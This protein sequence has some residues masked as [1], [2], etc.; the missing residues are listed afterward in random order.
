[1]ITPPAGWTL[2]RRIDNA[3][4]PSNSLAVYRR[5]ATAGE[6]GSHTW[7]IAG[8]EFLVGGIQGFSGADT[9]N[10]LDVENGQSTPSGT[11]HSTPSVTTTVANAMLVTAHTYASSRT[12]TPGAGLT[13]GFDQPSGANS[14]TGQSISGNYQLQAAAGATGAK[15][16]TAAGNADDG[17]THILALRPGGVAPSAGLYFIH[18]DHLNT[19][20]LIANNVG[21]TVWKWDN[22]DPFG[23]N[24]PNENPSGLGTFTCNLRLPGQYFDKETNLHYNYFRDYDPAI[25]RYI[26]S[27][28]IGLRGGINTYGYVNQNP[29]SFIDPNGLEVRLVCRPVD[30]IL[31]GFFYDHCFVH[32]TCPQEN[33]SLVLS[34]FGRP[35]FI[36]ST[37]YTHLAV[38]GNPANRD[39]PF[40]PRNTY[41][42]PIT[43][44]CNNQDCAYERSV[45]NRFIAAPPLPY[46]GTQFNSNNFARYLITD[47]GFGA[48]LPSN[49][50]RRA[51]GLQP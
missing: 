35:L 40:S 34:L 37:G 16:A 24:A 8:G 42:A 22:D 14:A 11:T 5:T 36:D 23:N 28:P 41:N 13:E 47:P 4:A 27:D 12:W 18:T 50:P 45:V 33:W 20:R 31:V 30:N 19:P 38:P 48:R 9:A 39:D 49:A 32:V 43:P 15:A 2:V 25:G 7:A 21:Q 6:P 46:M 10:P 17:N 1:M 3:N 26:Q 44:T 29:L 51:P